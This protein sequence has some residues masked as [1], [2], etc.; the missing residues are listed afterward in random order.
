MVGRREAG[1]WGRERTREFF[2]QMGEPNDSVRVRFVT[3]G[4]DLTAY[5]MQYEPWIEGAHRPAARYDSAHGTPHLDLLGWSGETVEK[6]WRPAP[7]LKE[8]FARDKDDL[9]A[10]WAT[11][12]EQF[13]RSKP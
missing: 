7:T 3:A 1:W 12:R 9:D 5:T 6:R 11:Y 8:A 4:G 13:V 2:R 10:N